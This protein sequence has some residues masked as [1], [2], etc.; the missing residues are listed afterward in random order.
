M[1]S[2][3]ADW[4]RCALPGFR[5]EFSYPTVTPQG[6]AVERTEEQAVD[7]RGDIHR[8]HLSSPDRS[9]LYVEVARFRGITPQD[10]YANHGTY[11][12]RR[13]GTE[14]V[15]DLTG[16]SLLDRQAWTYAFSWDEEATP[17]E[18]RA[19][20]LPVGGDTYRVIYDPR[21]KLNDEVIATIAIAD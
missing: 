7:H 18:R 16:A 19:L 14:N 4:T 1:T 20:L 11:L 12:K 2:G 8:V 21:S 9:E 15:T 5:L 13:F 10:E 17:M 6:R 3:S